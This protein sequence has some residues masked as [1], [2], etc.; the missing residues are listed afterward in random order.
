MQETE[1]KRTRIKEHGI[2]KRK[3]TNESNVRTR[4]PLQERE[5]GK[6]ELTT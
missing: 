3:R 1:N 6:N 4:E 2:R 5:A